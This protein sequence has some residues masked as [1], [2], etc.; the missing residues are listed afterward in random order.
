M[1]RWNPFRI[2]REDAEN[3]L[4]GSYAGAF[5]FSHNVTSE[6]FLSMRYIMTIILYYYIEKYS[7]NISKLS[8]ILKLSDNI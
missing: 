1:F 3:L 5:I 6:M 4:Q 8:D 7:N 2:S